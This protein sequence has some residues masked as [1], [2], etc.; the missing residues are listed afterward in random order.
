VVL[1]D[2]EE[3]AADVVPGLGLSG[4]LR[5]V[6]RERVERLVQEPHVLDEPADA[7]REQA[8]ER[9]LDRAE[10]VEGGAGSRVRHLAGVDVVGGEGGVQVGPARHDPGALEAVQGLRVLVLGRHPE[11]LGAGLLAHRPPPPN[12]AATRR[13]ASW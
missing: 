4:D 5:G 1:R 3:L 10:R 12:G 7:G 9:V 8:V 6:A 11:L 2:R 13:S